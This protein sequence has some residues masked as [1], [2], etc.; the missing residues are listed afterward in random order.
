MALLKYIASLKNLPDPTGP[1]PDMINTC[2]ALEALDSCKLSS[3]A[4][5]CDNLGYGVDI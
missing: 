4:A 2:N 1:L 3:R 5:A